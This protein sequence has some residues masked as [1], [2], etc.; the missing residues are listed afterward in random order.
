MII[1][2]PVQIAACPSRGEGAPIWFIAVQLSAFGSYRPPVSRLVL[3]VLP[4]HTSISPPV[5]SAEWRPRATGAL[6]TETGRQV[7]CAGSYAAPEF[8]C[9]PELSRPPQTITSEPVQIIECSILPEAA[10]TIDIDIHVFDDG[11]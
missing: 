8:R 1:R 4:P 9:V 10:P 3:P 5:Q 11:W 6:E 7:F 2:L